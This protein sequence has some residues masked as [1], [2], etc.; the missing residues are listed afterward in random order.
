MDVRLFEHFAD[1]IRA[2]RREHRMS[3]R[4]L[5]RALSVSPGYIGQWELHLSQPSPEVT[6]EICRIFAIDDVE[7]VQRLAFAQRAPHWLRESIIRYRREPGEPVA[8]T[9]V[10][11]RVLA[12]LRQLSPQEAERLVE[13]IEGWVEAVAS[14]SEESP[15]RPGRGPGP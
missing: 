12:A 7:Y 14:H 5:A 10:E 6:L 11:A 1:L 2:L 4:E 9:A 13:R 15:R 3:Q 8:L